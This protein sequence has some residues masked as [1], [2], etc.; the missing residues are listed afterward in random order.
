M[1]IT[2]GVMESMIHDLVE[3]ATGE[4][5]ESINTERLLF[6]EACYESLVTER[7]EELVSLLPTKFI[8]KQGYIRLQMGG[9]YVCYPLKKPAPLPNGYDAHLF[10]YHHPLTTR[11]LV[12]KERETSYKSNVDKLTTEAKSIISSVTTVKRLFEVWPECESVL[13]EYKD[14]PVKRELVLTGSI[15]RDFNLPKV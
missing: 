14:E 9:S 5:K 12:L 4:E 1:R 11:Y 7:Q 2:K 13:S 10:D 6:S 15:N 8:N 3:H